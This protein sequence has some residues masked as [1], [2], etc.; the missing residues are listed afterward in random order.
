MTVPAGRRP[1]ATLFVHDL[2]G[3]AIVRAA[4]LAAA[5]ESEF[6]VELA[7]LL[8]S[9]PDVY[10]PFRGRF[11]V[12][13]LRCAPGAAARFAAIPRLARLASG[14]LLY[15]CKPLFTTLA[16]ALYAARGRPVLLDVEDDE[17]ASRSVD[18]PRPGARGLLQRAADT[19]RWMARAAHP[20]TRGVRGVT[21]ATRSLQARYGGTLVRHGPDEA[22]FDPADPRLAGRV[23]LRRGFGLP[24]GP[25]LAL[26][27]GVPRPHKGW[28]TL[29]AALAHPAAAG[30]ELV[31][32]GPPGRAEFEQAR[33]ALGGRF[34]F[35]GSVENGRMPALLAACDAAPVPQRD[36]AS[37]RA[38]LPAKALEAMAMGVPVVATAVGDL[39][40]LLG[41]GVR[42]WLVPPDDPAAL[43][44]ALAAVAA[45]PAE[46]AGR[47]RAARAWFLEQAGAAA[48]RARLLP[49]A[50][51]ALEA[52]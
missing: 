44:A 37:A 49:L 24:D 3:N 16:P 41:G 39:P 11:A 50:R 5:L 1:R 27:A 35:V 10:A 36:T 13:A 51:A 19:H 12:R 7:G 40:E 34:H 38:Q 30:W 25:P 45:R 18:A 4:P 8:L 23:A 29:L 9:G 20:L 42:G 46:A 48:L 33:Q 2:A 28:A 43:A 14:D 52:G 32:A 17:W 47:A 21:V 6:D 31:A 26:F 15:A 22:V